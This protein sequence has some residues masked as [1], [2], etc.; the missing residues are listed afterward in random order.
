MSSESHN[1]LAH[2]LIRD[3]TSYKRYLSFEKGVSDNT[4]NAYIF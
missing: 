2:S 1:K 4:L 3:I